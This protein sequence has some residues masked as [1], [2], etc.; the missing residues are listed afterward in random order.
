MWHQSL[1]LYIDVSFCQTWSC[2][3][4]A[5]YLSIRIVPYEY[6]TQLT[7]PSTYP[8]HLLRLLF[9][10]PAQVEY[11][12]CLSSF[13]V[14][15]HLST[16]KRQWLNHY[17]SISHIFSSATCYQHHRLCTHYSHNPT[18]TILAPVLQNLHHRSN[19]GVRCDCNSWGR[20]DLQRAMT[21]KFAI[22]HS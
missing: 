16:P 11:S 21:G 4:C 19:A 8:Q 15:V 10:I 3:F 5:L 17:C 2:L 20:P 1:S 22:V 18:A 14:V 7:H 12:V 6:G 9:V 13:L